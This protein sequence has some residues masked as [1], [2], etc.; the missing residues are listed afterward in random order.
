MCGNI[1]KHNFLRLNRVASQLQEVL[2]KQNVVI[3]IGEALLTL[4]DLYEKMREIFSYH[5]STIAESLNDIRWG[6]YEYLK[7]EFRA[8]VTCTSSTT[9][10]TLT[11]NSRGSVTGI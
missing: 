10:T 5:S 9:L 11:W 3:D 8:I 7:P 1:A 4:E 6:I 2:T